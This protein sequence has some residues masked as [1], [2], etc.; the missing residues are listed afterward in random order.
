MYALHFLWSLSPRVYANQVAYRSVFPWPIISSENMPSLQDGG[1]LNQINATLAPN[2]YDNQGGNFLP[3][4]PT[5][6]TISWEDRPGHAEI[7]SV[8]TS[9]SGAATK[10][11]MSFKANA[12]HEFG[13]IYYDERGKT[14]KGQP[15]WK[16]LRS[17]VLPFRKEVEL[18]TEGHLT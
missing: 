1:P 17:W 7:G 15:H 10:P 2:L 12:N 3:Q 8:R 16:C 5:F 9:M 18:R 13:V 6:S 11:I 4:H 14:R